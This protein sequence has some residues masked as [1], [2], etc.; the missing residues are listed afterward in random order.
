MRS[1]IMK[2]CIPIFFSLLGIL[3][4]GCH[5]SNRE[6]EE[7]IS[8]RYIHKYGYDVSK[9]EWE[10]TGYPGQVITSLRNGVTITASYED[11]FLHGPTTHTYPYSQT[12]ESLS[13]YE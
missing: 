12:M 7:V 4:F 11:N 2:R 3:T 8:K 6:N 1:K 13:T 10:S 5:N 9:E